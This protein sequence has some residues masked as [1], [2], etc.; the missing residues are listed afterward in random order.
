MRYH[1]SY[2]LRT[3][4]IKKMEKKKVGKDVE[5]LELSYIAGGTAKWYT[6]LENNMSLLI[7]NVNQSNYS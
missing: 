6:I 5:K 7:P 4:I 1:F 3:D 2:S